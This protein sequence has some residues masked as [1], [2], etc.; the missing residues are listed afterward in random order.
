M[1]PAQV[2]PLETL[3]R[4]PARLAAFARAWRAA[5]PELRAYKR[6]DLYDDLVD[7]FLDAAGAEAGL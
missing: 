6:L 4:E 1:A 7:G 5:T 3:A 2:S